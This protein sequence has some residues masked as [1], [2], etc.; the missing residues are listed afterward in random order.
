MIQTKEDRR[1]LLFEQS[2]LD[3]LRAA[4]RAIATIVGDINKPDRKRADYSSLID[5]LTMLTEAV[6]PE[7][8]IAE[9]EQHAPVTEPAVQ[10]SHRLFGDQLE[11]GVI[12]RARLMACFLAGEVDEQTIHQAYDFFLNSP[13]P[14]TT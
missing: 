5:H 8:T 6:Q 1:A 10:V 9:A 4:A 3:A 11:R 7:S 13:L 14:L 12:R 2:G